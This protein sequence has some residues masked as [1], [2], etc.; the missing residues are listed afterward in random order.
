MMTEEIDPSKMRCFDIPVSPDF[1]VTSPVKGHQSE[2]KPPLFTK[3]T[4]AS[5]E[6]YPS[7]SSCYTDPCF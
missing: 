3:L 5:N 1:V 4:A 7:K 6:F 2:N